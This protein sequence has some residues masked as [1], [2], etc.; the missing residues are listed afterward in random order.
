MPVD[1]YVGGVEHATRHLIY[2][3][4]WHKFLFDEGLVSDREP[5]KVLKNQGLVAG[6]DGRKMSKR[7]GN[8]ISPDDVIDSVGADALRIY[9]M[10]IGPF[11]NEVSWNP[12]GPIGAHRFL[13]RVWK[14]S[15]KVVPNIKPD[16]AL[17]TLMHKT[18]KKVSEDISSFSFNTAVSSLMILTNTM[19]KQDA[20]SM[21]DF[22]RLL[23]LLAPLAPHITEELW[24]KLGFKLSIHKAKWPLYDFR[25]VIE[26]KVFLAV[27]VNGKTR[28]KIEVAKDLSEEEA[29]LELKKT[30]I[31]SRFCVEGQIKRVVYVPNKIINVV[32]SI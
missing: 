25:K 30:T 31:F 14:L 15:E 27:Q 6:P 9:S 28:G 32:L 29:V 8:I 2:A 22:K 11:E 18:I 3:R 26:D 10:F 4:F 21:H 20:L 12:N 24:S 16:R 1:M 17:T 19:I 7:W 5:F 13:E 23:L